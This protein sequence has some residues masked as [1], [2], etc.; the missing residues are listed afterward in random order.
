MSSVSATPET[1]L[2]GF[3]LDH[4]GP[5]IKFYS[6]EVRQPASWSDLS[7]LNG[8]PFGSINRQ[9]IPYSYFSETRFYGYFPIAGFY[10]GFLEFMS[11]LENGY[12]RVHKAKNSLHTVEKIGDLHKRTIT[13]L[14]F[15]PA[16]SAVLLL[17]AIAQC[18]RGVITFC[19]LGILFAPFDFIANQFQKV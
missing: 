4:E 16:Q 1:N 14:K 5:R 2:D 12:T 8:L 15:T 10:Y 6:K 3:N 11:G 19:Q 9:K 18:I 7:K 17:A 13:V